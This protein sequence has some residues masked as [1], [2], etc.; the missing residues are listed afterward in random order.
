MMG[1][2]ATELASTDELASAISSGSDFV[3]NSQ[4]G[5]VDIGIPSLGI[6]RETGELELQAEVLTGGPGGNQVYLGAKVSTGTLG[7]E[8]VVKGP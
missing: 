4:P 5:F 6:C 3:V 7:L 2:L 1:V 8:V